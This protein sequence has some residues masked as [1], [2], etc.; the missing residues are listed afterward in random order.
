MSYTHDLDLRTCTYSPVARGER[1]GEE[2]RRT[3]PKK[4]NSR[5]RPGFTQT[6]SPDLVTYIKKQRN[7]HNGISINYT[8][9]TVPRFF[10]STSAN[11]DVCHILPVLVQGSGIGTKSFYDLLKNPDNSERRANDRCNIVHPPFAG[12]RV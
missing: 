7:V 1:N 2:A 10:D 12:I 8:Y 6:P 11:I 9:P 4:Q 3:H 5:R